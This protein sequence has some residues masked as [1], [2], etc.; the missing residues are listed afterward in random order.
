VIAIAEASHRLNRV[1]EVREKV[2]IGWDDAQKA[3]AHARAQWWERV[4]TR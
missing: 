1:S 4:V 3:L 2:R